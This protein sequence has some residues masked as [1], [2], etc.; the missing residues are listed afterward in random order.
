MARNKSD[1]MIG[2]SGRKSSTPSRRSTSLPQSIAGTSQKRLRPGQKALRE[3]R[4]YQEK[5]STDLLL[6]KLPFARLVREVQTYFS[7]KEY[8]FV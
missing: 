5:R 6:R 7:S 2:G 3:I 8:R 4:F 1:R